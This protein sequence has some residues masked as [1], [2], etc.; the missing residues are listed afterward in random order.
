MAEAKILPVVERDGTAVH[1]LSSQVRSIEVC[2]I[3][4]GPHHGARGS[5]DELAQIL[6]RAGVARQDGTNE[7]VLNDTGEVLNPQVVGLPLAFD[8]FKALERLAG[9]R[10]VSAEELLQG[11][12]ADLTGR[13]GNHGADERRYAKQWLSHVSWPRRPPNIANQW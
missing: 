11:F 9:E 1:G 3:I 7:V 13:L 4:G 2:Q 8:A 5:W 6:Q 12:V 10:G